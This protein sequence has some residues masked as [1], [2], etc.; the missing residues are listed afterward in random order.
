MPKEFRQGEDVFRDDFRK[1]ALIFRSFLGKRRFVDNLRFETM[2][3]RLKKMVPKLQQKHG[4]ANID[5]KIV[6]KNGKVGLKPVT[7]D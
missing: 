4:K 5:F 2:E 3:R 7:S 6:L 1:S